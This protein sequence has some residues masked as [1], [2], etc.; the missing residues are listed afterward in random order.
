[1]AKKLAATNQLAGQLTKARHGAPRIRG[2]ESVRKW[3]SV[4]AWSTT[5]AGSQTLS[6]LTKADV[7]SA[8]MPRITALKIAKNVPRTSFA[9]TTTRAQPIH[10]PAAKRLIEDSCDNRGVSAT[11]PGESER[12]EAAF[13]GQ[14]AAFRRRL[15]VHVP[16]LPRGAGVVFGPID[17][18]RTEQMKAPGS[19]AG[20]EP[21]AKPVDERPFSPGERLNG[22]YEIMTLLGEGGMGQVFEAL[23][24]MLDRRV[25]IKVARS[26]TSTRQLRNEARALAAFKH[27]SLVSVHTL[28]VHEGRDFLVMERIYGINL[29]DHL[30]SRS[31]LDQ[32]IAV[33][34]AVGMIAVLAEGLSVVHRAGLAHRDVK[35]ENVMLTPDG[36][37]VLMDFGLVLPEFYVASQN[38]IAGSPPYMA[39]ETLTNDVET[40]NGYLVDVYALGVCAYEIL[41]SRQP[42]AARSISELHEM[43]REGVVPRIAEHRP[44]CPERLVAL[45]ASMMAKRPED[46]PPSMESVAWQM[47]SIVD[48][49]LHRS[50]HQERPRSIDGA[51]VLIVDDDPDIV[52]ILEFYVRKALGKVTLRVARDGVE[53]MQ[54]LEEREPDFMLLDLHMPRMN[55]VDVCMQMRGRRIAPNTT[56]ISVSAGAQEHDRQLMHQLGIHHFV[57]KGGTLRER[58]TAV[59]QE[60]GSQKAE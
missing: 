56:V 33:V 12:G 7:D 35:L 40:G 6:V 50:K 24:L 28:G 2:R 14:L 43:H 3:M 45:I 10:V 32:P 60:V 37:V 59:L 47:R 26:S 52:R 4:A 39:P 44:D 16:L 34:E 55:G 22:T 19:H 51:D 46:R 27:P 30:E 15:G 9:I 38:T 53:A 13:V 36:R 11:I 57:E 48:R 41:T 31:N 20:T 42:F 49:E 1:M 18:S 17:D 21:A 5:K 58:L 25:A 8:W 54:R 29:L 23:D